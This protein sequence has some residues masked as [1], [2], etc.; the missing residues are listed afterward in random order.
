MLHLTLVVVQLLMWRV[1]VVPRLL[2][3]GPAPKRDARGRRLSPL[4]SV[5]VVVIVVSHL[6]LPQDSLLNR[7]ACGTGL[8]WRQEVKVV[9][10]EVLPDRLS[11]AKKRFAKV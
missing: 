7:R 9:A 8:E 1:V 11:A 4:G 10:R 5:N 6:L 3:A 2:L